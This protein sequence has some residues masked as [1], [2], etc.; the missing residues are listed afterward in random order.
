MLSQEFNPFMIQYLPIFSILLKLPPPR[1]CCVFIPFGII[2]TVSCWSE[3]R[4]IAK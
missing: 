3:K 1:R 4:L 2:I